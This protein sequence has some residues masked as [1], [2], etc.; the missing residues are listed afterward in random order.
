MTPYRPGASKFYKIRVTIADGRSR[1]CPCG[2]DLKTVANDVERFYRSMRSARRWDVL[3]PIVEG[4]AKLPDAYDH[5]A[6]IDAWVAKVGDVD[7]EPYVEPWHTAK[8]KSRKGAA[9]AGK[10]RTQ[11]RELIPEG[12]RYARSK[13]TAAIVRAHLRS[14]KVEDPTRN[15]HKAAF[16]S[17]AEFL[18][19]EGVIERNPIRDVKGWSE[20]DGRVMY[21][22]REHAQSI[23]ERLPFPNAAAEALM[24]GA[25]FEW[26]AIERVRVRDIDLTAL[27]AFAHGGKTPWRKRLCRIVEAWC[28]EYIRAE[29]RGKHPDALVFDGLT[30]TAALLAHKEATKAA[31]LP[32]STNHDW[33]HTHAVLM[34]RSGYK[35]TVVA[36]QLGHRD[37]SLVWKR[38]GRFVIDARDYVLPALP[39]ALPDVKENVK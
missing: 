15:R 23:I 12:K 29:L 33:R 30:E 4:R 10:Y 28:V 35:P 5:R 18:V 8:A 32:E 3:T 38:Y 11:V 31:K 27:T 16:S 37:T 6:D 1:I 39:E 25:G 7:I 14:L 36:H 20:G 9:S 34:L 19:D 2:T 13:F 24:V 22:E 26:Q 17:F 21:Y